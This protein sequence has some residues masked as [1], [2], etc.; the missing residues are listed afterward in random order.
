MVE[1][2]EGGA[3]PV[4]ELDYPRT[5][6]EFDR[7]FGSEETCREFLFRLR[8][9]NGFE[10]PRCRQK[11][12]AWV[13]ARGHLQCRA[14]GGEISVTAGTVFERT[15]TP[16]KTWFMAMWFV[17]SQKNG[18]SALGLQ[19][20]LGLGIYQTAWTLLHKLRRAMVRPGRERLG[21]LVEVDESYVGGEEEGVRGR[22]TYKKA[23]VAIAV[24]VHIPKGFGRVRLRRVADVSAASLMPFVKEAIEPGAAVHT[25][26]WGAYAG[27][28]KQGYAHEVTVQSASGDPAHVLLPAVH[29]VSSLLKRWLVGTHQ[30][31]VSNRH[32]DYYLDEYTFRFNRRTSRSRGLLFYRLAQQAVATQPTWYQ[33]LI[34]GTEAT[35]PD[36]GGTC[37]N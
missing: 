12:E 3:P 37:V 20:I 19:R 5:F 25:D 4:A 13:T 30:G 22:E 2:V 7:F 18:A 8:W 32:L 27:L 6:K 28:R 23:I 31:A 15:R 10:C 36:I 17:T 35:P 33:D 11:A 14:C 21:G 29:R 9:P 26:G 16:L 34:G 1:A 24:E